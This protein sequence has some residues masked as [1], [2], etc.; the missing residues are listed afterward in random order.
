MRATFAIALCLAGPASAAGIH[1]ETTAG[2]GFNNRVG[3]RTQSPVVRVTDDAGKPVSGAVVIF[4]A[5]ATGPSVEF[6]NAFTAQAVTDE[7][8]TAI[9]PSARPVGG[10]GPVSIAI[11]VE[12]DGSVTNGLVSQMNLGFSPTDVSGD[13]E[14]SVLPESKQERG[15]AGKRILRMRVT[16]AHGRA[17]AGAK[18]SITL[19]P[20][21]NSVEEIMSESRSDGIA[22]FQMD[23]KKLKGVSEVPARASVNDVTATRFVHVDTASQ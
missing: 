6:G 21:K 23:P 4:T 12:K 11:M 2:S 20:N 19:Y 16:D 22:E 1:I 18:V 8:G 17:V 3:V 13:M 5:P 15:S 10:D 14:I 7:S 9:A